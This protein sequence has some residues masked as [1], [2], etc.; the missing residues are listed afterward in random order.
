MTNIEL[1]RLRRELI[2]EKAELRKLA[3]SEIKNFPSEQALPILVGALESKNNDV[4]A[5]IVNVLLFNG[6]QLMKEQDLESAA[7]D[8]M[9]KADGKIHQQERDVS[10]CI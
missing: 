5:D 8:T 2:S 10:N 7:K 1:N 6:N 4:L 9:F 3:L